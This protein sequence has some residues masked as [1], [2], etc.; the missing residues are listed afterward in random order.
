MAKTISFKPKQVSK[1]LLSELQDRALDVISNRFGLN[2]EAE[3]KTLEAI[4][5]KYGITRERVRQIENAALATIRKSDAFKSEKQ[6]FD[7]LHEI[8]KEL[9]ALVSEEELLKGLSKDPLTQN[10]VHFYLVLGD[11]FNKHKE[12]EHFSS[13]WTTDT[14]VADLVHDALKNLYAN[15]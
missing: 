8:V 3:R 4:G 10:H 2:A 13:R 6:V 14:D 12:D 7:E 9:G 15:L 1:K 11:E 5:E